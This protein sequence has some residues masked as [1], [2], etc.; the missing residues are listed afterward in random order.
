MWPDDR[1]TNLLGIEHPIIQAPMA[2]ASTPE[3]AAAAANSGCLGSLGCALM[4][5]EQ[6]QQT[7]NATRALTNGALNMNFFCHAEP[8]DDEDR[9]KRAVAS[10][11]PF[12]DELDLGEMPDAKPVHFPFDMEMAEAVIATNPAVVS[13]HFGLP[14]ADIVERLKEAGLTI[15]SSATTAAEARDLAA[16]GCDAIIAQGWEAG[17]HHGY[18]LEGNDAAVGTMALVPQLV[19]EVDVPVIAAGGIADGRGI[20][21]SFALGAAGVQIGTAFLT[22][23]E[24]GIPPVHQEVLLKSQGSD[25][26]TTRAFSGRPARGVINRYIREMMAEEMNLPDFPIMNTLSGPLR[27]TSGAAGS[28]DFVAMW[29]GQAVGLNRQSDVTSLV[30]RLISETEIVFRKL[31]NEI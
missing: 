10:L 17:G 6:Y 26:A 14:D 23:R 31:G 20:A 24:T 5:P 28:P 11:Q 19:D 7:F 4:S 8:G 2:G 12:Y 22:T 13:F 27:K 25:T 15:L 3:M 18:Y 21:A 30:K 29:S 1:L 16:R 9:N